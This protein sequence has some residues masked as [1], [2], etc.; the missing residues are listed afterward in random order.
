MANVGYEPPFTNIANVLSIQEGGTSANTANQAL[1]N[2]GAASKA[3]LITT[4][5]SLSTLTQ[6]V[7]QLSSGGGT[8][9]VTQQQITDLQTGLNNEASSR[10]TADTNLTNSINAAN[11]LIQQEATQRANADSTLQNQ[12]NIISNNVSNIAASG[13]VSW[14]PGTTIPTGYLLCNGAIYNIA[15]YPKLF[16]AIGNAFGGNGTTTF[17]VPN[18]QKG[19]T[20]VAGGSADIGTRTDGMVISHGH[21]IQCGGSALQ[22]Q[23][24]TGN[25]YNVAQQYG[26]YTSTVGSSRNF[27]AGV[28]M[29]PVIKT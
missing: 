11:G 7:N 29:Q 1:I 25:G 26:S 5:Q 16:A 4:N 22:N 17:A 27:A 6:T 8:G 14:W 12:I 24:A 15:D 2:L 10:S 18:I 13:M 19:D 20:V 28:Y 9:T 3:D 23:L 21:Y